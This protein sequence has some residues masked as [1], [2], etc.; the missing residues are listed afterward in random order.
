VGG[1]RLDLLEALGPGFAA[2]DYHQLLVSVEDGRAVVR[3]DGVRV[4]D[5]TELPPGASR[6]GLFTNGASAAF[7]GVAL[8]PTT[9]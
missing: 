8:T 5:G 6:V 1:H 4:S 9:E 7:D 2:R 3:L